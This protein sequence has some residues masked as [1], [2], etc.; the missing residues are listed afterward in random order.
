MR[1]LTLAVSI[2]FSFCAVEASAQQQPRKKAATQAGQS[3]ASK[4]IDATEAKGRCAAAK[5]AAGM[6]RRDA[7]RACGM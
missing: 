7:R 4:G 3:E 1:A 5:Q 2:A 6:L